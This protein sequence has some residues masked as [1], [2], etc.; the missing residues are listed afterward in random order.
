[1]ALA[2]IAYVEKTY[3]GGLAGYSA[4]QQ[5]RLDAAVKSGDT[6]LVG[7]LVAD[8][9]RVGYSLVMPSASSPSPAVSSPAPQVV[10]TG[11]ANAGIPLPD[12]LFSGPT[13]SSEGGIALPNYNSVNQQAGFMTGDLPQKLLQGLVDSTIIP[14]TK[15]IPKQGDASSFSDW[16]SGKIGDTTMGK[17]VKIAFYV[18]AFLVGIELLRFIRGN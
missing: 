13:V 18:F 9:A 1:M 7:R 14:E 8:A 16:L 6:G 17:Y 12:Y 4:S 2:D 5:N 3:T 10:G 11:P 15:G